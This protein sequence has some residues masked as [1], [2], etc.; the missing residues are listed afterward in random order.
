MLLV[1]LVKD[2]EWVEPNGA[3]PL[4]HSYEARFAELLETFMPQENRAAA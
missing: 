3:S 1:K 2:P 4:C